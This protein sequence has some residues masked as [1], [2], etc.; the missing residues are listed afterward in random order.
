MYDIGFYNEHG[1][2]LPHYAIDAVSTDCSLDEEGSR[3]PWL[4]VDDPAAQGVLGDRPRGVVLGDVPRQAGQAHRGPVPPRPARSRA[5]ACR[6][7]A[8][9]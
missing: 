8:T 2:F 4:A 6:S 1:D 9:R 5:S 3:G 7:T